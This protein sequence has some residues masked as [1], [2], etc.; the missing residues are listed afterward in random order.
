MES[1]NPI[2]NVLIVLVSIALWSTGNLLAL[3]LICYEIGSLQRSLW[4]SWGETAVGQPRFGLVGVLI[5]YEAFSVALLVSSSCQLSTGFRFPGLG[6]SLRFTVAIHVA[7][8]YK[9]SF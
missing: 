4:L 5:E 1:R 6:R 2:M 7:Y 3:N 9:T 8:C